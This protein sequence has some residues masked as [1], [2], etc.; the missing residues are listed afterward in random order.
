MAE[1]RPRFLK[2]RHH[3]KSQLS[4]DRASPRLHHRCWRESLGIP[5]M[6]ET[7]TRG[8]ERMPGLPR[9]RSTHGN[10]AALVSTT[11]SCNGRSVLCTELSGGSPYIG[12]RADGTE[13][14][15]EWARA[16]G[17]GLRQA[18]VSTTSSTAHSYFRKK[19]RLSHLDLPAPIDVPS[20]RIVFLVNSLAGSSRIRAS[21]RQ[22]PGVMKRTWVNGSATDGMK[23]GR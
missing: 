14:D 10:L 1:P 11:Q 19:T 9:D 12:R 15:L 16:N 13:Q 18:I 20:P 3:P 22:P 23:R 5:S 17:D 4:G 8:C 21:T 6:H 7:G 2:D